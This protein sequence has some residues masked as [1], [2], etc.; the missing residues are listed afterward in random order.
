MDFGIL[1]YQ[2]MKEMPAQSKILEG[3]PTLESQ[4]FNS[5]FVMDHH[6]KTFDD[7]YLSPVPTLA[8]IAGRT[9]TATLGQSIII[10]TLH[11]PIH[12]AE[13][14]A[15]VDQLSQG[16]LVIGAGIGWNR[17]E[18]DAFG[19]PYAERTAIF[20]QS[21]SVLREL[22]AGEPTS[23]DNATYGFKDV[24]LG[25]RPYGRE[26]IPILLAGI[27]MGAM[28]RAARLGDGWVPSLWISEEEL[29][30]GITRLRDAYSAAERNEKPRVVL[31]RFCYVRPDREQAWEGAMGV[32]SRY[33]ASRSAWNHPILGE[34]G[35]MSP[36]QFASR[37]IIGNFDDAIQSLQRY[38]GIGVDQVNFRLSFE[39]LTPD[40][41]WET[42]MLLASEVMPAFGRAVV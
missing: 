27:Q 28:R 41:V 30:T 22:W 10:T 29:E 14:F 20:E 2:S 23:Y 3:L 12:L 13:Q 16:R 40:Q 4:G 38:A 1:L 24:S 8:F 18:F 11:H 35:E 42:A 25:L 21:I 5:F 31:S 36:E 19:V 9:E 32:A 33:L 37:A 26:T 15:T 6:L 34:H 39:G 7:G 17:E